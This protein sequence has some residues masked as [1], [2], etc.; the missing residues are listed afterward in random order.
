[1]FA[2][3]PARAPIRIP[4]AP[5]KWAVVLQKSQLRGMVALSGMKLSGLIKWHDPARRER[6]KLDGRRQKAE[7]MALSVCLCCNNVAK[8]LGYLLHGRLLKHHQLPSARPEAILW[9]I[10]G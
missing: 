9:T 8:D 7:S 5:R 2:L 10:A 4:R 6:G 1:M 3:I